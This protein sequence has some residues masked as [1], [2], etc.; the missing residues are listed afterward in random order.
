MRLK[1]RWISNGY[2]AGSIP[3]GYSDAQVALML[4]NPDAFNQGS[5]DAGGHNRGGS[6]APAGN[7]GGRV[8]IFLDLEVDVRRV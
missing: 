1:C 2:P 6:L 8:V 5:P 4:F 7:R 3:S